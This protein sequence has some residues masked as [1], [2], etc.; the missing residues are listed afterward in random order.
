MRSLLTLSA[1]ASVAVAQTAGPW[2]QCGGQGW[3]GA[4]TCTAGYTCTF[5]NQWYSQCLPG[6]SP[7]PAS[8]T[9][10]TVTSRASSTTTAQPTST[11]APAPGGGWKWFGVN[12][13]GGEFGEKTLP[14]T[15]GKEFIF[16]DPATIST[17]R[18][19]G[20]NTFRIQFKMERLTPNSLTGAFNTA[21]LQNF[22]Q[23]V[24]AVT[25]SGGWAVLDPHNYGRFY[26]NIITDTAAF[27]TWWTNFAAQFKNNDKV[28]F[29]TN[30]EYYGMDQTLVL[31]LNQAAINGIRA[32]GATQYIFVEGNQWSGAWSW[33][34][35]NDNMKALT[36][37]LNKIV[38]EMHQYLDSD[39]SG[40]SEACVSTTIGVERVQAATAW[41]RQN[42]KIGILGEFAGGPN[43]Q[44]QTA[45]KGL[46][47]YL[48]AN[49]DVWTGALWWSAGPWWG[50]YMYSF[51][52]PSGVGYTY[53]NSLLK[54]YVAK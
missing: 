9:L 1:L 44:C 36:D 4:T 49:S 47:D 25:Q 41:L 42:G 19:Q 48:K 11:S 6:S 20:Y 31:N 46:L 35:V 28:I 52:P 45:V 53:Y 27:Q 15:W 38:Y 12:E 10:T 21:Y 24:N 16:P 30:N 8:T 29:D 17:L 14:G 50:S 43:P 54:N 26:D 3:P 5:S 18:G 51:E 2:S 37:P 7:P 22:T 33:T 13:A 34:T 39:S 32:T 40:T 23:A